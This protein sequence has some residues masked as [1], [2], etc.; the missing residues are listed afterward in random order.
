MKNRLLSIAKDV[1][2]LNLRTSTAVLHMAKDYV[3]AVDGV[4]RHGWEETPSRESRP[5]PAPR[6]SILLVGRAGEELSA[7]FALNNSSTAVLTAVPVVQAEGEAGKV[8]LEPASITMQPGEEAFVRLIVR[9][10]ASFEEN[11]TY[12]GA[13]VV[14]ALSTQAIPFVIRRLADDTAQESVHSAKANNRTS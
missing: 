7:T 9:L 10:T 3:R 14:P 8:R 5:A 2:D 11:R 6:P 4:I 1:I 13:V 12:S